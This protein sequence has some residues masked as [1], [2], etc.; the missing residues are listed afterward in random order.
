MSTLRTKLLLREYVQELLK[1]DDYGGLGLSDAMVGPYGMHY[2]SGEDLYKVFI[3][4]FADVVGVAAGK[5]KELSEKGQTLVKVAFEAVAT[6]LVPILRDSYQEIFAE[7]KEKIDK[8]RGEYA[9]VYQATWDAFKENDILVAAFMYRPDLFLN[10]QFARKAPA[11][12]AKLLS[13]VTGGALDKYLDK[14]KVSGGGGDGGKKHGGEGPGVPLE[15]VM[16]EDGSDQQASG[17]EKLVG[18]KKVRA[19]LA[20]APMVQRME[21][22]GQA[23]VHETLKKVFEQAQGV[24]T[25]KSLEDLQKKTGKKFDG[26]DKL[27]QVPQQ[28]RQKAEQTLLA[29]MKKSM[30][31]FYVKQLEG[32]VKAA[33][34]AGVPKDHPYINDYAKVISKIKA[35]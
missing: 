31:E 1:E 34:E 25:A 6:T 22:E 27:A 32:Q 16:R 17:L 24:L 26:M 23:M 29:G 7:E 15:S 33:V 19:F 4:P 35:L 8:I 2:G 30:K 11:A 28:E 3:K 9:E 18:H 10:V 14:F 20:K 13:V 5:T 21:R 12:A